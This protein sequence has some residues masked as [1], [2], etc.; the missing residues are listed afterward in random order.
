MQVMRV[1]VA[2]CLFVNYVL[3]WLRCMIYTLD[4]KFQFSVFDL[5]F[6]I[7]PVSK[8]MHLI[9]T[10]TTRIIFKALKGNFQMSPCSTLYSQYLL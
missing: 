10:N 6:S 1:M 5:L 2:D 8:E 4:L 7:Y 3:Y 9:Y